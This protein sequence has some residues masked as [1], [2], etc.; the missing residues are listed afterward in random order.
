M[1][2]NPSYLAKYHAFI[3]DQLQRN[4][5]ETIREELPR[6]CHNLSHNGV[7]KRD[8]KDLKIRCVYKGSA[9]MKE[10]G[11]T[12]WCHNKCVLQTWKHVFVQAQKFDYGPCNSITR[13]EVKKLK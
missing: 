6:P 1:Q 7:L 3:Q 9:K 4:I 10:K 11:Y 8:D 12:Y 13:D 2:Q 5:I